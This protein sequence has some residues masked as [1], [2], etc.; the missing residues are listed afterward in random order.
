MTK[1]WRFFLP[2][3]AALVLG[4]WLAAPSFAQ[5]KSKSDVPKTQ[6]KAPESAAPKTAAPAKPMP[7]G[8]ALNILIRR[9]LLSINDANLSNNYSVLRD[10]AAPGFQKTNDVQK[11]AGIFAGLRNSKIDL[12]PIVYFDPKLVRPPEFTKNGMLRLTGFVPTQPQ[13]VN[14]DMLF[15]DVTGAWRLYGIAVNTSLAKAAVAAP[16]AS[17]ATP[18]TAKSQAG[19]AA[20]SRK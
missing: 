4:P 19:S 16:P 14:F 7:E 5:D 13:Q 17:S 9:T 10:L 12:A 8:A 20:P 1:D 11:L 18:A 6:P 15:E 3:M 2:L